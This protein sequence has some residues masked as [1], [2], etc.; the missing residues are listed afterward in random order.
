MNKLRTQDGEVKYQSEKQ[1]EAFFAVIKSVRD[2]AIFR[3]MYHRGLRASEI[4]LLE[5]ADWDGTDASI[6]VHRLK[7]S[8][9]GRFRTVA[10]EERA[11]RAWLKI[12]GAAPGP[13][14]Q[15]RNHG[16]LERTQIWRL[17][18]RYGAL[19]G[20]P[21]E[22]AHPHALKHSCGTHVLR[23]LRDIT[24]VQDHL[25]HRAISSTMVYAAILNETRDEAAS[26]LRDWGK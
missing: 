2:R 15:S 20:V 16:P 22:L 8:R 7:R 5:L 4:G 12:R 23:R 13:L 18:H 1:I 21:F 19:A 17:V 26:K 9:S 3:L 14:F 11:I 10:L 25:G 24:A 6:M